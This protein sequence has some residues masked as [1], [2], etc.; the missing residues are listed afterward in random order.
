MSNEI[1]GS[2]LLPVE[3]GAATGLRSRNSAITDGGTTPRRAPSSAESRQPNWLKYLPFD[4]WRLVEAL[5]Q[6]W[7][8][9]VIGGCGLALLG[10]LLSFATSATWH[11]ASVQLIRNDG[12]NAFQ[13][14]E[15]G[16]A[17]KPQPL[18]DAAFRS[19]L[20]SQE[21]LHRVGEKTQPSVSAKKLSKRIRLSPE[22]NVEFITVTVAGMDPQGT[23]NLANLFANEATQLTKEIQGA[24]ATNTVN[25]LH[26][27][28]QETEH[29]QAAAQEKLLELSRQMPRALVSSAGIRS[30][31]ATARSN[32]VNLLAE[33]QPAHPS[34]QKQYKIIEI[35]E[36]QMDEATSTGTPPAISATNVVLNM[37]ATNIATSAASAAKETSVKQADE[38]DALLKRTQ[39]RFDGLEKLRSVLQ[40]RWREARYFAAD[41]S[42]Y[43]RVFAAAN[44]DDLVRRTPK[45]K[46][47]IV[48]FFGGF[49]GMCLAAVASLLAEISDRRLKTVGDVER[50]TGL[51]VLATLGDLDSMDE[52]AQ[53]DWAFRTWTI[54]Q[55]KLNHTPDRGIVCGFTS[56]G[57]GEGRTTWVRLLG[58][59]AS[60]R[61]TRVLTITTQPS[62]LNGDKHGPVAEPPFATSAQTVPAP[63]NDTA[64]ALR[65]AQAG[66]LTKD[67]LAHPE[68]VADQL[69][70]PNGP[71]VVHIPLPGWVWN[72]ERRKQ[73]QS[74]LQHW[75]KIENVVILVELPP[76]SVPEAVLLAEHVPQLVWLSDGNQAGAEATRKQLETLR[77]ARCNLVGAVLNRESEPTVKKNILR[78]VTCAAL[79]LGAGQFSTRA[80]DA[81]APEPDRPAPVQNVAQP[82][83]SVATPRKR[84]P[85]QERLTLGPG[86]VLNLS[87]FGQKE[88]TRVEVVIGPDG[89]VNYLQARDIPATGLTIDELR[90]KFDE[91]LAM[92]YRTPRTIITPVAFR[93]KKY[94]LLGSVVQ[95][96]VF[97]LD[98]P[99]T[100]IEAIARARGLETGLQYRNL[101]EVADLQRTFLVR[102]GE[103]MPVDFEKLFLQGDLSQN[104]PLEP[105]DY[106]YFPPADLK[107]VYVV[108][109]VRTPGAVPFT[110]N[111]SA[112]GAITSQGG[113][114]DRAWRKRILVVRGSLNRPETFI[115]DATDV[116]N[117][118]G[119]DFKL[120]PRDIIYVHYRPW[121]KV[122]ELLDLAATAFVQAAVITWTGGNVGPLIRSP[123]IK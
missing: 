12:P 97:T 111:T 24:E 64:L 53:A 92:Y 67:V 87:L 119:A 107:E 102:R 65:Q 23:V 45:L 56:S 81:D 36:Q 20:L 80:A 91:A 14:T 110:P 26:E 57:S 113:F 94:F 83:F 104:V 73:W 103:R 85:W 4:P 2:D 46:I 5:R 79:L 121:I 19:L 6:R 32:L 29:E 10:F 3:R 71:P 100:I 22:R 109:E 11:V 82:S 33:F 28:V 47:A 40:S 101:V 106:L 18:S 51:P 88:L 120:Q 72:Y 25:Y 93:S 123:I 115:V 118:R 31:L 35:L 112:L 105:D 117:A 39:T 13:T 21:L 58:K 8:W 116:L 1:H 9:L 30:Q 77:H 15:F 43:Y 63:A 44:E 59:A 90:A 70:A 74:A 38:L 99:M 96:G 7:P 48:T 108:G 50:V 61:G 27:R 114:T 69:I 16:E 42:G 95:K 60:Q 122:E 54:F 89:L 78:W 17:F 62:P 52:A 68:Q 86:D 37:R 76:A 49:V 84:A 98:R 34:V 41:P 55:G 66:A 75:R